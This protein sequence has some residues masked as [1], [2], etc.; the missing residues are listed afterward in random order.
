M[1]WRVELPVHVPRLKLLVSPVVPV[2]PQLSPG[3]K[4]SILMPM[5]VPALKF[6]CDPPPYPKMLNSVSHQLFG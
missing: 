3:S 1:Y 6:A 4:L 2:L 5:E